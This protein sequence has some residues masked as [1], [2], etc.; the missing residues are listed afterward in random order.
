MQISVGALGA[1]LLSRRAPGVLLVGASAFLEYCS[2]EFIVCLDVIRLYQ[3]TVH[4]FVARQLF[5]DASW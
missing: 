1:L 4:H 3:A 5:R 2:P